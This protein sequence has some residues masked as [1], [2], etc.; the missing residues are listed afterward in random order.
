MKI[1]PTEIEELGVLPGYPNMQNWIYHRHFEVFL[2]RLA[3]E[4][5][6]PLTSDS[7]IATH[8]FTNAFYVLDRGGQH[9]A[10]IINSPASQKDWRNCWFRTTWNKSFN[11]PETWHRFTEEFGE[12]P[13]IHNFTVAG[14]KEIL[15]RLPKPIFNA[16]YII[17]ASPKGTC[18]HEWYLQRIVDMIKQ[19]VPERLFE[20][21]TTQEAFNLLFKWPLLGGDGFLAFQLVLNL[22]WS[23]HLNWKTNGFCVAGPGTK[24]GLRK[25][26]QHYKA[27][28]YTEIARRMLDNQE[29]C[30]ELVTGY[31]MPT[32]FGA[33]FSEEDIG[34]LLCEDDKDCRMRLPELSIQGDPERIKQPYNQTHMRPLDLPLV[35]PAKRKSQIKEYEN[36]RN[37]NSLAAQHDQTQNR[38]KQ[39]RFAEFKA[40][41]RPVL[42]LPKTHRH[43]RSGLLPAMC[44]RPA[45]PDLLRRESAVR[46]R[47]VTPSESRLS[48][49]LNF[50]LDHISRSRDV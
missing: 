40:G 21:K 24:R 1:W 17:T 48:N 37:R 7:I 43:A 34:N 6:G 15:D 44:P 25:C 26:F 8:K 22:N 45:Y 50:S 18:K 5:E 27:K 39:G 38:Q 3:G 11:L 31:P 13:S 35:F 23:I 46:D 4:T 30:F 49:L 33:R 9:Q 14:H 12:E 16:A 41:R 36:F 47:R 42:H 2:R 32:L 28:R 29:T 10:R 19:Q 20:C